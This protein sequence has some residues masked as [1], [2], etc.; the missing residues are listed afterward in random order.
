VTAVLECEVCIVGSGA[1][2]GVMAEQLSGAGIKVVVLERGREFSTSDFLAQD[3]LTNVLRQD[4]FLKGYRETQRETAAERAVPGKYSLMAHTV[5]G[6]TVHWGSWSWR[7]RPDEFRVL[8]QEGRIPG[9]STADWPF[10]YD[11]IAPFYDKAE[12]SLGIAGQLGAN[13]FAAPSRSPYPNPPH[14]YRP[15]SRLIERGARRLGLNPFPI[16]MAINSRVYQ[17]R[18][19]CMN[20]GFCSSFGC[21]VQAKASSLSVFIPRALATGNCRLLSEHRAVEVLLGE[22]GGARGVRFLDGDGREGEVRARHVILSGGSIASAQLLLQST[23]SRHP[24]GLLNQ[25]D[26]VGRNL[27]CHVFAMVN[28]EMDGP[29]HSAL[30]PPGNVAVDDFHPSDAARGFRRGAVIGEAIEATP[31][32]SALKASNYLGRSKRV[33]GQEF[34]DYLA[35]YPRI[36]G[37]IAVGEDMPVADNRIDLDPDYRDD[38]GLPLPRIT[39]C[40]HP[41]DIRLARYFEERMAE[42]ANAGGASK[43]WATDYTAVKTGS[44]HILGTCRMGEDPETSVL[45]RWCR[46]H[47]LANLWV[48]DGSCF[49]S[50]GGYNPT[51]TIFANAYRVADHFITQVRR[52]EIR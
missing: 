3:E 35:R 22:D 1:G 50:S 41:N 26:Q 5:G 52:R 2:G 7:F 36:G 31:I 24:N 40:R 11:E 37:L 13:P 10:G 39:H 44:G 33:W 51:L 38:A 49:P 25:N 20:S 6:S 45:N 15:A 23:S 18:A 9:S 48:V 4:F 8:S 19:K 28:F 21:P 42:I 12:Q 47:E 27:M 43:T 14:V 34:S 17:G 29:S 46:A 16:P 30:G 32:V